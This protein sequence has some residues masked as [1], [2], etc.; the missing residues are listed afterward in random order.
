[1][2]ASLVF[3]SGALGTLTAT[4][5]AA[6]G[7]P[8]RVEVY[9]DQ[10]GIQIEGESIVRAARLRPDHDAIAGLRM[11]AGG[12]AVTA[13]AGA[14]PTGI[15]AEGHVRLVAD[16]V[17]AITSGRPPLVSGEEGRRALALVYAIYE[18]ARTG[19]PVAPAAL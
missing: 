12:P 4:T 9:G 16:F 8:H 15:G 3:A 10:G 2:T 7:F 14:S 1:M 13:G 11:P 5:S 18:A 6:P 17:E 19:R